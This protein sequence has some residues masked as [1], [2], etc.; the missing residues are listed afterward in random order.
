MSASTYLAVLTKIAAFADVFDNFM[1]YEIP[2]QTLWNDIDY[3][4]GYR[5]F[6]NS[7]N[8]FPAN[9]SFLPRLL[10]SGRN[11]IPIIDSAVYIPD[12]NNATDAYAPYNRGHE[13][14]A[15]MLN[16][17]GTEYIG[18]VWRKSLSSGCT[19]AESLLI[20]GYTVFPDWLSSN[21]SRYW[22]DE[23]TNW[24]KQ[25]PFSGIWM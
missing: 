14:G 10:S 24:H 9:N 19:C 15:F 7:E 4:Q 22:S 3:M 12:P 11:Y 2:L 16:P 17:D 25:I 21:A 23:I 5:D 20:A 13:A 8:T 1:R 6:T 18:A